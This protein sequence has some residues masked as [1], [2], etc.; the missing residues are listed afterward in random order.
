MKRAVVILFVLMLV[1]SLCFVQEG[2][3]A[4]KQAATPVKATTSANVAP[5]PVQPAP[6]PTATMAP[7]AAAPAPVQPVPETAT[8]TAAVTQPV[9]AAAPSIA[10]TK[11]VESKTIIGTIDSLTLAN[12]AKGTKSEMSIVD[13]TGKKQD[14]LVKETTTIYD[15]AWLPR[16]LEQVAKGM[17]VKVRYTTTK[18]GVNE[19][20]SINITK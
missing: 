2:K 3:T 5:A 9:S 1:G 11:A 15:T 20:A 10:T 8:P 13:N 19:A 7:L 16:T 4:V 18:E 14:F 12:R 17:K 6:A